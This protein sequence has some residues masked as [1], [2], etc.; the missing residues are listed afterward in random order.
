LHMTDKLVH[1]FERHR[2]FARCI[3][4]VD[5]DAFY[6]AVEI[7]DQPELRFL[8]VAVGSN[9]MLSTSN[10]IARRYGVRAGLP[11]FLGKKLCPNLHIIPPD[12][13][14][15]T[16][17]SRS[18]RAVLSQYAV[19]P[20]D[21]EE[22]STA[23]RA[24]QN[25]D[26]PGPVAMKKFFLYEARFPFAVRLMDSHCTD[27]TQPGRNSYTMLSSFSVHASFSVYTTNSFYD[28]YI[29]IYIFST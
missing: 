5:M 8:P 3:V 12:F 14:R 2:C 15:Y 29:Y 17:A 28:I 16:E 23:Q 18:V 20:H 4:H 22:D 27:E 1:K 21:T 9:S 13:A 25:E 26:S 24:D 11:G 6:A 7:R 19:I 10:Y